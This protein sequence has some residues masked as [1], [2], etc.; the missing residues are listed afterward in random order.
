[1]PRCHYSNGSHLCQEPPDYYAALVTHFQKLTYMHIMYSLKPKVVKEANN[2][3]K[4]IV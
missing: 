1:M 3:K 4:S 2:V